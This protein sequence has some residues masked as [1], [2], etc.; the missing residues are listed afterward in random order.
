[1]EHA[2]AL[3]ATVLAMFAG[4]NVNDQQP[5]FGRQANPDAVCW[6]KYHVHSSHCIK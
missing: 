1:M 2:L 5:H 3:L 6:I 4:P